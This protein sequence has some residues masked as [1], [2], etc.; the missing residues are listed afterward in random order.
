M[1]LTLVVGAAGTVGSSVVQELVQR[2][3]RV[4]ALSSRAP[5]PAEGLL[6]WA[7]AD[8]VGGQGLDQ[9]FEGVTRAFL[10]AP[11]GHANQ[12]E[13]LLPLI[14]RA[15][16]AGLEKVVLMS[17]LGADADARAPLRVAELALEASG[18]AWNTVRPNWFMQNFSHAWLPGIQATGRIQLP[19][20]QA[21]TSFID[22]RDIAAVIARL[23][24]TQD[25]EG[26]AFNLT[27]PRALDFDE[28][29]ATLSRVAGRPIAYEPITPEALR[30]GLLAAGVDADYAAFLVLI[31]G[32][33]A[34][35][36]NAGVTGEVQRLL[37]RE[38]IDFERYAQEH[39]R[40]WKTA[41]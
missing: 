33:L 34:A 26:Q 10:F 29:A 38:P 18:L 14:E 37:G 35:G 21:K 1:P 11:P 15:R 31:L 12:H 41:G 23:L 25:V 17:A 20:G 3:Q 5:R 39:A 6:E 13:I 22:T 30:E 19:A 36:Y 28:A 27:G 4:R 24:T 16:S 7:Q 9:A 2:G 8:V 32:F 40:V